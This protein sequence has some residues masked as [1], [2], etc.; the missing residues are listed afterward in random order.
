MRPPG[1]RKIDEYQWLDIMDTFAEG[2]RRV[3]NER[4][5]NFPAD[6]LTSPTL[7]RELTGD[8]TVA[9]IDDGVD[10]MHKGNI[11]QTGSGQKF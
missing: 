6:Y 7:P 5:S 10:F 1:G 2:I 3:Q 11:Q 8:V 4:P 9:L